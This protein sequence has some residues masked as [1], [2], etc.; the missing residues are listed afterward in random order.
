MKIKNKEAR[1]L[2]RLFHRD[3]KDNIE[4]IFNENEARM[5]S[6]VQVL[7]LSHKMNNV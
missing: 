3:K 1:T 7:K 4:E 5:A 2:Y 6:L